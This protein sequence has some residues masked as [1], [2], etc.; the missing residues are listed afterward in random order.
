[1]PLGLEKAGY[2]DIKR[3]QQMNKTILILIVILICLFSIL[4][5]IG[6]GLLIS[7]AGQITK[8]ET[9]TETIEVPVEIQTYLMPERQIPIYKEL[10]ASNL[11]MLN[12][13]Y[14]NLTKIVFLE[15]R[16]YE[17]KLNRIDNSTFT[18][19]MQIRGLETGLILFEKEVKVDVYLKEVTC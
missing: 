14:T 1:M 15:D 8:L 5:G 16:S 19:L 11:I 6:G 18:G 2:G 3:R 12:N 17:V 7:P 4:L 10:D 9:I 13:C